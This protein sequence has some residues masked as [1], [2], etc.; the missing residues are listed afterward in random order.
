MTIAVD[1]STAD[2]PTLPAEA[3]VVGVEGDRV[4][5]RYAASAAQA[6]ARVAIP[7]YA[8]A[9]G[10]RVLVQPTAD[11]GLFVIGVVRA[12]RS[13]ILATPSGASAT[14]E[15]NALS[16]RDREGHVIATLDGESG[17]LRLAAPGDLKLSAA[18]RV[19]VDAAGDVE[20]A[21]GGRISQRA[22][23]L[24]VAAESAVHAIGHFEL[25]AER[26]V[27]RTT[28]ALRT[29][30]GLVE[31]RAKHARTLVA[32]TFELMSRRTSIASEEDTRVDGKRVLLG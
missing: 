11:A 17:E 5:V 29:A 6:T 12:S 10:D 9:E 25:T 30:T 2:T 22:K 13:P 4:R 32:R 14:A 3:L 7:S 19:I 20:I 26:I 24:V 27:E 23:S 21:S 8:A 1:R 16:L 15:G 18:G 28:D 31:T